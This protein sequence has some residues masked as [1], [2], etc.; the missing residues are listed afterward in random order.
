MVFWPGKC[1]WFGPVLAWF[2]GGSDYSFLT[3]DRICGVETCERLDSYHM[4]QAGLFGQS[5][6]FPSFDTLGLFFWVGLLGQFGG[7]IVWSF[8][9]MCYSRWLEQ[10][11]KKIKERT[12]KWQ[13][14]A[15]Q[16]GLTKIDAGERRYSLQASLEIRT[17]EHSML[18]ILQ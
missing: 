13:K 14:M 17:T 1:A 11:L 8:S 10:A 6:T 15:T 2:V 9:D 4:K 3:T 16:V 18:L 5:L 7:W 12:Y